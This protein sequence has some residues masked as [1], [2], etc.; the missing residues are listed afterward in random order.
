M[1]PVVTIRSRRAH[2]ELHGYLERLYGPQGSLSIREVPREGAIRVTL[3][4]SGTT[5]VRPDPDD[6]LTYSDSSV[7]RHA[8]S[9]V[10]LVEQLATRLVAIRSERYSPGAGLEPMDQSDAEYDLH[11]DFPRLFPIASLEIGV[12]WLELVRAVAEV[13]RREDLLDGVVSSQ[14]KQKFASLR[15]Y[16]DSKPRDFRDQINVI[17]SAAEHLSTVVCETCG[18]PGRHRSGGWHVIAC[19]PC[20]E[21]R[22]RKRTKRVGG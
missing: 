11:S 5:A 9:Y 21:A 7:D 13:M 20:D 15:W 19:D 16:F 12:P 2:R 14:I 8:P 6:G 18:A 3:T 10:A 4:V 1:E 17:I 22:G